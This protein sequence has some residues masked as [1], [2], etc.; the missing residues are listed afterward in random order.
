MKK[1]TQSRLIALLLSALLPYSKISGQIT[2]TTLR[3]EDRNPWDLYVQ[4]FIQTDIML[5]FQEIKV[6]DGFLSHSIE[7]P[8]RNNVS[9]NFSIKQSQIGLGIKEK[10]KD[11]HHSLSAYVEIDFYGPN[12]STAPRF[13]QGYVQWNKW[14]IGQTWSNFSDLDIFPNIFDFV[15]PNALIFTR[16]IQVRY[17]STVSRKGSLSLSLEDPNTP[18]ITLPADSLEWKKKAVI[19]NITALYRY[20]DEKNYIKAGAILSPIS[21]EMKPLPQDNYQTRTI[22]GWGVM[23]SGKLFLDK[24]NIIS[25]QSSFGKGFSTNN[26]NLNEEKYDAVPDP[27]DGNLLKTLSM[28]N[29]VGIYEHWWT[30]KWSSVVFVSHSNM[31]NESFIP[32]NMT[33][34][35]QNIGMNIVFHPHKKV[36]MGIETNYGRRQNF[37]NESAHAWRIQASTSVKF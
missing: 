18:S 17:T 13:R 34:N 36:R 24:G 21:Y 5:N 6:K 11:R 9:S 25:L 3:S 12:G 15:P 4:G 29:I 28:F 7:I 31:G 26:S 27:S 19:P 16:R 20:G 10:N 1:K 23:V 2:L 30:P 35:F 37:A 32:K 14:L 33:K 22:V 8:Q